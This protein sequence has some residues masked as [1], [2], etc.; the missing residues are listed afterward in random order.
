MTLRSEGHGG[1]PSPKL[2]CVNRYT[3]AHSGVSLEGD[4]AIGNGTSPPRERTY[5]LATVCGC[6]CLVSARTVWLL[7]HRPNQSILGDEIIR[8]KP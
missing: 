7:K 1:D 2:Q 4:S 3:T 8:H 5:F 6:W